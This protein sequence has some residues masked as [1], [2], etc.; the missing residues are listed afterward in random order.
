MSSPN[1]ISLRR[2]NELR[3]GQVELPAP[4]RGDAILLNVNRRL[5]DEAYLSVTYQEGQLTVALKNHQPFTVELFEPTDPAAVVDLDAPG[6][7]IPVIDGLQTA[8][9]FSR[10]GDGW[11]ASPDVSVWDQEGLEMFGQL[12]VRNAITE[13]QAQN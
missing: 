6:S 11:V 5:C 10:E 9:V 13:Q 2:T 3:S 12:L 4:I 1:V 7:C 8:L